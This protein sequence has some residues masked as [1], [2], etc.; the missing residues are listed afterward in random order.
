MDARRGSRTH[1]RTH[2]RTRR[3]SESEAE[4]EALRRR[5]RELSGGREA[6]DDAEESGLHSDREAHDE[7]YQRRMDDLRPLLERLHR[8]A[9]DAQM[10]ISRMR[11]GGGA[12]V[13]ETNGAAGVTNAGTPVCAEPEKV[14]RALT[15]LNRVIDLYKEQTDPSA[16]DEGRDARNGDGGGDDIKRP[17]AS[18]SHAVDD[19]E[20]ASELVLLLFQQQS[21]QIDIMKKVITNR[22]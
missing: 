2:T 8:T 20:T 1:T 22:R 19:I 14:D 5:I 10:Q 9:G 17:G 21:Q 6:R 3:L 15:T 16:R 7:E 13:C 18:D 4:V 11:E 12:G